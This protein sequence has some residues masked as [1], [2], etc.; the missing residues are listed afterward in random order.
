VGVSWWSIY[1]LRRAEVDC[2]K[3]WASNTLAQWHDQQLVLLF[4]GYLNGIKIPK[5]FNITTLWTKFFSII[6][7]C[8]AGLPVGSQ[9]VRGFFFFFF[10]ELSSFSFFFF[11]E[12]EPPIYRC[13]STLHSSTHRCSSSLQFI[14]SVCLAFRQP[15]IHMGAAFSSGVGQGRSKTLKLGLPR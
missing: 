9:G 4:T 7:A 1:N 3:L 2:R 14:L 13:D 6:F 5:I 11:P 10:V 8:S 15:L 12:P